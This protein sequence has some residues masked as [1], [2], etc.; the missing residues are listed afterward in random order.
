MSGVIEQGGQFFERRTDEQGAEFLMPVP[1]PDA[2]VQPSVVEI[3]PRG[4][5]GEAPGLGS[6]QGGGVGAG[7]G[8][9]E[10]APGVDDLAA[11]D[12][13]GEFAVAEAP[14]ASGSMS[15]ALPMPPPPRPRAP[16]RLP[17][18][19]TDY[20]EY[21][22]ERDAAETVERARERQRE[23][24]RRTQPA[25]EPAAPEDVTQARDAYAEQRARALVS[26]P[27]A[28]GEVAP[29]AL[30][31]RGPRDPRRTPEAQSAARAVARSA[32]EVVTGVPRGV[33]GAFA[34][35]F[36][37]GDDLA[38]WIAG[39]TPETAP[40]T[41]GRMIG[42]G[43][44]ALQPGREP[45]TVAGQIS[46]EVSQFITGF[47]RGGVTLRRF[48]VLQ[49]GGR[50]R[51]AGRAA[52]AGAIADFFY[53]EAD[54][55]N[56][57]ALWQRAGLP[58]TALTEFLATQ[59]DDDAALNRLRNTATG[60]VVGTALEG[61]VAVARA[62]RAA[63]AAR[64]EAVTAGV[65]PVTPR[66]EPLT[67]EEASGVPAE[68]VRD[69]ILLGDARRP[70]V[71]VGPRGDPARALAEG[72]A[73]TSDAA[74]GVPA[75]TMARGLVGEA[76][77]AMAAAGV[78]RYWLHGTAGRFDA[79]DMSRAGQISSGAGEGIWLTQSRK[80][81]NEYA[82]NAEGI[83][84]ADARILDVEARVQRPLIVRF[85]DNGRLLDDAGQGLDLFDNLEV[86][87]YAQR[88]GYD[89]I[90]WRDSTFTDDGPTLTLFRAESARVMPDDW[91]P[92]AI[93]PSVGL[94]LAENT[95]DIRSATGAGPVFINWGRMQ[96]GEDV[97]AVIRDMAEA[98]R[99]RINDGA[100]GVQTNEATRQLADQLGLTVDDLLSRQ[101]GEVWN[102]ETATAAR[103]LYVASGE[104][105]LEAARAA[106]RPGAGALD[107]AAFRRMMGIHYAIQAQVLGA[108]REAGRAVQAWA[109]PARAGGQQMRMIEDLLEASGGIETAQAMAR[110]L[111]VLADNLP[112]EEV[113]RAVG[114]FTNRG[115]GGRSIE[116]IQ[117]FWINALLSSPAT[118]LANI[119]GNGLNIPLNLAERAVQAGAGRVLGS[120]DAAL[121]GEA[122]V[123]IYG[124]LTGFRDALRMSAR[125]YRDDGQAIAEMIGRQD[126]P[127]QG[128]ISSQAFGLD[129]GSGL[130]RAVD[131]VGHSIIS[132]PG[133]A[134]GAED[135]FFKSTI[136]RMELHAQALR[137]AMR[138]APRRADGSADPEAVGRLMA[139][140][141]R[142]PPQSVQM[143]AADE[144]L[145][146]TF[147]RAAG[148]IAR[149]L[150]ALRSTDS[151]GWNLAV[152]TVLPFIR[153]PANLFS[154]GLER[155][156]LAPVVGQWRAD[157][158]AG[159]ARRDAAVARVALGS[160]VMAQTYQYAEQG[161]ISGS[162][163]S[164]RAEREA[165]M[166]T[167]WQP[168]SIRIG[169]T[170]LPYN[171][172]DP[173]GFMLGFAAD[174][175][176][177]M[178]R[179]DLGEREEV[180]ASR[181]IAAGV[182][183]LSNA[184]G[185][186]SFFRGIAALAEAI[187]PRQPSAE[188]YVG[189][190]LSTLLVPPG[191]SAIGQAIDPAMYDASQGWVAQRL[192]GLS[193][194]PGIP[195]RNLWGEPVQRQGV[196]TL[197]AAGAAI[198]PVRPSTAGGRPIDR[199]LLRLGMGLDAVDRN[200]SVTF[201][202]AV[203]NLRNL[204]PPALDQ[205][206]RWAGNEM[207]LPAF[208]GRGLADALDEMV[209]GRGPYGESFT[210]ASDDGRERAIRHVAAL[211]R[212][213]ARERLLEEP[214]F[215]EV[216]AFVLEAQARRGE[217]RGEVG[218]PASLTAAQRA[219]GEAP[220]PRQ[221]RTPEQPALR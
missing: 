209:Q 95:P 117:Q 79:F 200:G 20:E 196:A 148:P 64:R 108:R 72:V 6:G 161:L 169:N 131:F 177:L 58:E 94:P 181:L 1:A 150:M 184:L 142:D 63:M 163:P 126:L 192:A 83:T 127:R 211:Y 132:A 156:P 42:R 168:Y 92:P 154:Y 8:G 33:L 86:I 123:M 195:R 35:L 43:I 73:A 213:A 101:S 202:Q 3:R 116:A 134:M 22:T 159:G 208:E 45:E 157:F 215:A 41:P 80:Y 77:D 135:A 160:L 205:L 194:D 78:P 176:E 189:Q 19:R 47:L 140:I 204:S 81:A 82:Q 193:A 52:A 102:A 114:G 118:H 105:L 65:E 210:R 68:P 17:E 152:S 31:A 207:G 69:L 18:G 21:R 109:I 5:P 119:L 29:A 12:P 217:G 136:Y 174:L 76:D 153:T 162:G 104:R 96:A 97:Q 99:G 120:E 90:F 103:D 155:T 59:P 187:D 84:G 125:T 129:A 28:E 16:R 62:G 130:G 93:P 173:Y 171:R 198:S 170:W 183:M 158:A 70:L 71:E 25:P 40:D 14:A 137:Q 51:Q 221:R 182:G 175:R 165:L 139:E 199:E 151:P 179:R 206:R 190:T 212:R 54:E 34:S 220:P 146:R 37:A 55:A 111:A 133:R 4:A 167:G 180:E 85:D 128:A 216:A 13:E 144:A 141:V 203:V 7:G 110:R 87:R 201:G 39:T 172:L 219:P 27:A 98:Y 44:R 145:Y 11:G 23:R 36:E 67:L 24:Q 143:A 89:S 106:A 107:A 115:W 60:V 49:G 138:E 88:G 9:A 2:P 149:G 26:A 147:N 38:D 178:D 30:P 164:D 50:V 113:A 10:A 91:V 15:D 214:E 46:E 197:G 112:P 188:R 191:L 57:A 185:E 122:P 53:Q 218:L 48:G 100:R 66:A 166:R 74:M 75:E 124:L 32:S 186:R 56:L 61:L 121:M